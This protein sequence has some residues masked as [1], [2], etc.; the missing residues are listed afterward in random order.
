MASE[1]GRD[2]AAPVTEMTVGG[3]KCP[4]IFNMEAFRLAEDLYEDVYGKE[5]NFTEIA[6]ELTNG[7]LRAIMAM[8]YAAIRAG[9]TEMSWDAFQRSFRLTDIPG[10]QEKLTQLLGDALPEPEKKGG[11]KAGPLAKRT[12]TSPGSGSTTQR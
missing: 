3:Q 11:K 5:K 12:L 9:G 7:R 2:L 1:K 10:V 6:L 4:L 8:Y